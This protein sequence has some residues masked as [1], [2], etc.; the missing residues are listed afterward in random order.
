MAIEQKVYVNFENEEKNSFTVE[1]SING[2]IED[3]ESVEIKPGIITINSN[4]IIKGR[5]ITVQNTNELIPILNAMTFLGF[6]IYCRSEEIAKKLKEITGREFEVEL[7]ISPLVLQALYKYL[8]WILCLPEEKRKG[9]GSKITWEEIHKEYSEKAMEKAM[10]RTKKIYS[11]EEFVKEWNSGDPSKNITIRD[12]E[13]LVYRGVLHRDYER[14]KRGCIKKK[15][16]DYSHFQEL[17]LYQRLRAMGY[18]KKE[19]VK[20]FKQA[21]KGCGGHVRLAMN[22]K[23]VF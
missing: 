18:K 2:R 15:V 5:E 11:V 8:K 12:I 1:I 16:F 19:V 6:K 10:E 9:I 17:S 7:L 13:D 20:M 22:V 21:T 14:T 4:K 23:L 3:T